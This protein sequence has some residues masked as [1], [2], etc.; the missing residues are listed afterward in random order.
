MIQKYSFIPVV[1][2]LLSGLAWWSAQLEQ[3]KSLGV[4]KQAQNQQVIRRQDL[5]ETLD[6]VVAYERY[7]HSVYGHFT[8]L[9]NRIGYTPPDKVSD[10]YDIRVAEASLERL[11]VTA[12]S[13]ENGRAFEIISVDQDYQV[14]ANFEFPLPRADYLKTQA[15]KHLRALKSLPMIQGVPEPGVFKEYF[16][17]SLN[18]D[19]NGQKVV[20]A[21]GVRAPVLGVRLDLPEAFQASQ[22]IGEEKPPTGEMLSVNSSSLEQEAYLAQKI[23]LGEMG[24]YAHTWSELS[25]IVHFRFEGKDQFG[26]ELLSIEMARNPAKVGSSIQPGESQS[27]SHTSEKALEIEPISP[28]E[29]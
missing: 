12:V 15:M 2:L 10:F 21:L 6:R 1:A 23:Y 20:Y 25:K 18:N 29:D 9:L 14:H 8:K 22:E 24:R 7:Y 28:I 13:E 26:G 19:S 27:I 11:L 5:L 3:Q 17:Y 16:Q 4:S